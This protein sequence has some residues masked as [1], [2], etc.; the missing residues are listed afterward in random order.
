M[1]MR[2]GH[3]EKAAG[4]TTCEV[5]LHER[6]TAGGPCARSMPSVRLL[7]LL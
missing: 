4:V 3:S 7:S 6:G 2:L 1:L 5:V